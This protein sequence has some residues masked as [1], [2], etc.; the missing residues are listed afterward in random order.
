LPANFPDLDARVQ[1][2]ILCHEVMHV[3]RGD[4]LIILAEEVIRS[5]FWFHPA[6]WWLLGEIGLAREQEVDRLA[7]DITHQRDEYMDALL[8]IAGSRAQMELAPAPLFLRRRHL[9]HRVVLILKEARMSKTHLISTL[10]TG[11]GILAAA[12]WLV[13]GVFPLTAQP[14]VIND[15]PGV[16]VNL[17]GASVL[18]RTGVDYPFAARQHEVQGTLSVE[19]LLDANGNVADE[20]VLSGPDE[21]RKPV[22]Q[23]LLQWHFTREVAGT[24]RTV[25]IQFELPK[26][27]GSAVLGYRNG[28]PITPADAVREERGGVPGGVIGVPGGVVGG[29]VSGVAGGGPWGTVLDG[30]PM[31]APEPPV[32]IHQEPGQS[33]VQDSTRIANIRVAGLSEQSRMELLSL[34]PVHE[35]DELTPPLMANVTTI[36]KAYDEHLEVRRAWM[37]SG[38]NSQMSLVISLPGA[39]AIMPAQTVRPAGFTS[40]EPRTV[41]AGAV[42]ATRI[43]SKVAPAYPT[44]AKSARVSGVV[45]L[46]AIIGSDGLVK[47]LRA[48]GGPALLIQSAMDA[49]KE[50]TFEPGPTAVETTIDINFTLNQ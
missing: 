24:T 16:T 35:G 49:V 12:C 17:N 50:W 6:I 44:L 5:I 3:R 41:V 38:P 45:H 42:E 33:I 39:Q 22:L 15:A 25:Q 14:R 48:L 23:S 20:H 8:A 28:V 19:V 7:I 10:T 40:T 43:V 9:K 11:L 13:T 46:A 34:L 37:T 18:H 1:E 26:Q 29:V 36:A 30:M 27:D 47:E 4:W 32:R 21:L 31:G 2:A